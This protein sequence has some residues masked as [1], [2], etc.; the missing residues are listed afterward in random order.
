MK[1][2]IKRKI[3]EFVEV[4]S[5]DDQVGKSF[6]IFIIVLIILNIIAVILET[7]ESLSLRY[8]DLFWNF[9]I[10]SVLVF[11]IEYL[12]RIWSCTSDEHYTHPVW[13]RIKYFFKPLIL[14]DLIAILPF[15][16]PL[17]LFVDLRTL[18]AIRLFRIFRFF[19]IGRYS[20]SSRLIGAVLRKKKEELLISVFSVFILLILSSSIMY[21]VEREAQPNEFSSIP[22]AMWWGIATLTTIG[23]GDIY[24]ITILGKLI[25][26]IIA[27]L[28]IG[29]FALPAGI[30]ASGFASEMQDKRS[31]PNKCPHCGREMT[32]TED[33]R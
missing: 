16:L 30:L 11:S 22:A 15:Y 7:V 29:L 31:Q 3:Y 23:Y 13:G 5:D 19:K 33:K 4:V 1:K 24:P 17:L 32:D 12:L 27:I 8:H 2:T 6:D 14:V 9:E 25:G 26:S 18:R 28:G 20:R 21:Y 10:F